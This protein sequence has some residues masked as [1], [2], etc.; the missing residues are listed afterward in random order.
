MFFQIAREL[1]LRD[2][3]GIIVVDFIDM[4]DDC[5]LEISLSLSPVGPWGCVGLQYL[6]V[7]NLA[8]KLQVCSRP[9]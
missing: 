2:I 1:R 9:F 7:K 8:S 5:K 6:F 3:G 4:T